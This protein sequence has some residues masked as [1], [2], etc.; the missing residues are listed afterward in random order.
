MGG[1]CRA[2]S[3]AA[4]ASEHQSTAVFSSACS[5]D[6]ES[7]HP[8]HAHEAT[9]FNKDAIRILTTATRTCSTTIPHT[10]PHTSHT[11]AP[12]CLAH[13]PTDTFVIDGGW[14][15]SYTHLPNGT[16]LQKQNLDAYGRQVPAPDR[17][18]GGDM[19][20][21]ASHAHAKVRVLTL[22][23][24]SHCICRTARYESLTPP[25]CTGAP[26]P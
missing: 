16:T 15:I 3:C 26:V 18:P 9:R 17:Y 7:G 5:R 1:Y 24:G 25:R 23:I 4:A 13:P 10:I 12:H 22:G 6:G 20:A 8:L 19:A 14:S 2:C 21:L 11:T